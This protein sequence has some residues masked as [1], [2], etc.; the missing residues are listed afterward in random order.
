M[1]LAKNAPSAMTAPATITASESL[2]GLIWSWQRGT[3]SGN[4]DFAGGKSVLAIRRQQDFIGFLHH[5]LTCA[6]DKLAC[7]A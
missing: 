3:R 7:V 2:L 4:P 5:G 1:F 6:R